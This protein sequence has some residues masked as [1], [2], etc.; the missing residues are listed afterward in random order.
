VE[1]G[2]PDK[3]WR[4]ELYAFLEIAALCGLGVAQPLLDITGKAPDFFLFY[5]AGRGD[6]LTLVLLVTVVPPVALWGVGA[7]AGLAGQV[8]ARGAPPGSWRAR[9]GGAARKGVHALT[10]G[11][12]LVVLAVQVGKN[13]LPV[14]GLPLALLAVLAS[15]GLTVAYLRWKVPAQLL[16]FASVGP[17]LFALL[18]VFAS[19]ASA[20]VLAKES[21]GAGPGGRAADTHPPVVVLLLDEFPLLSLLGTDGRIDAAKYPNFARLAGASTW[22]RNATAASGWT[23]YAVPAMLSG[24]WPRKDNVAPH[25]TQHPDNLFTLMGGEYD[26]RV[27]ESITQL[28]PPRLCPDRAQP[29]G[30]L[31][32]LLKESAT[33]LEQLVSPDDADKNL[34]ESY[35]EPTQEE[36]GPPADPRFR[37]GA[38]AD[39]QPARF[40]NFLATLEPTGGRPRLSFLHLLMPH[41]PWNYLASGARYDAPEDL[42]YEAAGW[43]RLGYERHLQQVQYTDKL[44]GQVLDTMRQS[45][46]LDEALLVVTADH[47]VSFSQGAA[48]RGLDA[49][50]RAAAEVLWVPLFVKEPRQAAG[51]VDDRNWEQVDLLPT[52]ADLAGV[53]VPWKTDG[54]SAAEQTRA[55]TEKEYH[56]TPSKPITVDGSANLAAVLRGPATRPALPAALSPDLIGEAPPSGARDAG[57]TVANASAFADV[58]P[59]SGTLPALVYGTVP[60]SV[61]NGTP[62]AVVVNGKVGAVVRANAADEAGRRFGALITDESLFRAGANEVAILRLE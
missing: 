27:Q 36:A 21:G 43:E 42:H 23:P 25:Y 5:G 46:I 3:R 54:I 38:L 50:Q 59:G 41:T 60:K 32:V 20:V 45:G 37:F 58:Q 17:V 52:I 8:L 39:N 12:L 56:D 30:G 16:R 24:E 33:L 9:V 4:R 48:G 18:F 62:L 7:L 57:A 53:T 29:A 22:Y 34:E 61:R 28:C 2:V 14:R 44:I 13:L 55:G 11:A 19:P 47:G 35:R 1:F 10:L 40:T 49:Q 6:V 31:P 26:L 51:R 15:A